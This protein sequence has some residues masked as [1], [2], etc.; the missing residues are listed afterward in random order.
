MSFSV[1]LGLFFSALIQPLLFVQ[2][3]LQSSIPLTP[4]A[5]DY[6]IY[7]SQ[8]SFDSDLLEIAADPAN[9]R[10][11]RIDESPEKTNMGLTVY[12]LVLTNSAK[13]NVTLTN[14]KRQAKRKVLMTF[15]EH[16]REFVSVESFFHLLRNLTRGYQMPC[17]TY[18]GSYSRLVLDHLELHL[19]GLVNPDGKRVLETKKDYC[20]RNNARGV[21]LNR[22]CDWEFNG[23]GSSSQPGHEEYN[24]KSAWSE[25][26]SRYIR[27]L[28]L[29]E[30][31][32]AYFSLHSGEQQ[33][34]SPFVDT[35]SK[36]HKRR[37]SSVDKELELINK[38]INASNGW[39]RN[40]G[41]ANEMN[42][43][44]ADGTFFDWFGGKTNVEYSICAEIWG[45][46][47][48]EDCFVMFNPDAD[49]LQKD[50]DSISSL[51]TISFLHLI[52]SIRGV[53]YDPTQCLNHNAP[54]KRQLLLARLCELEGA[55]LD[56]QSKLP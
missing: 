25:P 41:I 18:A 29:S 14:G 56:I 54:T 53:P 4:Y 6:S 37:R 12:R 48:H 36:K 26:E 28:A 45:G 49:A 33:V 46:P 47:F 5:P 11:L 35:Y 38:I 13:V 42:S 1:A 19:I 10:I 51:Y 55:L 39:Y 44:T 32:F 21:D 20:Y 43:Y 15:G 52:E 40:G 7:H 3:K 23:P 24:G 9:A 27:D 16:A 31:Y 2:A 30:N 17:S 8:S 50:L 22:N 34:F